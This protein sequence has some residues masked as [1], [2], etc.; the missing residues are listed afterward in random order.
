MEKDSVSFDRRAAIKK[1]ASI[2]GLPFLGALTASAV[3]A[4]CEKDT[5]KTTDKS[6]SFDITG[7]ELASAGGALKKVFGDNNSGKPVMI[8]RTS[9]TEFVAMTT[10]CTHLGCEVDLP[11]AAGENIKC[12]CHG[13]VF[14]SKDGSVITGP[15]TAPLQKFRTEFDGSKTLKIFF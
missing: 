7:T 9:Q 10:V 1:C 8:V 15:A 3:F 5:L 13:S 6:E 2:T 11:K 4:G 14:S 12:P